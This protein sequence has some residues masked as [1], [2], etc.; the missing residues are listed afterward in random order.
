MLKTHD[1]LMGYSRNEFPLGSFFFKVCSETN[2]LYVKITAFFPCETM[3]LLSFRW[4]M[5]HV[6]LKKSYSVALQ[7]SIVFNPSES[8]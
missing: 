5:V 2:C 4:K 1:L 7:K 3:W 8:K 6:F